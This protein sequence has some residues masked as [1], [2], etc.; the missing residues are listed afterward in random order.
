MT[1]WIRAAADG[2]PHHTQEAPVSL[3]M[4]QPG[5]DRHESVAVRDELTGE[6]HHWSRNN[7]VRLVPAA[8]RH[9]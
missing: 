4:P 7:Y 1:T 9:M 3:D 6:A 2:S 5:L 8:H